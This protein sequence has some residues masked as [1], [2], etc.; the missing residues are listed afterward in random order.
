MEFICKRIPVQSLHVR[1]IDTNVDVA[2]FTISDTAGS[3]VGLSSRSAANRGG[4]GGGVWSVL[5]NALNIGI[6]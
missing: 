5:G 1:A 6:Q 3:S 4:V 2:Q